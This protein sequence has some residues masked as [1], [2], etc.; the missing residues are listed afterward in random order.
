MIVR[1]VRVEH[2]SLF[3]LQVGPGAYDRRPGIEIT[4]AKAE[5]ILNAMTVWFEAQQYL[6]R[7]AHL[8]LENDKAFYAHEEL[9][10]ANIG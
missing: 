7:I 5:W 2:P 9:P 4:S 6:K 10:H 1:V 3:E 8:Q